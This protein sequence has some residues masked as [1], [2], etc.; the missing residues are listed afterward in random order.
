MAGR[1][2]KG[3]EVSRTGLAEFVGVALTTVDHWVRTGCPIV[4]RGGRGK[5]W[6]F[7]TADVLSWREDKIREESSGIEGVSEK[8]L[9][10]RKLAAQTEQA[11]LALA[12]DK[13][14]VAPI[15]QFER[16]QAQVFAELKTS[17]RNVPNRVTRM[18]I[19]E[20]DEARFKSVLLAELDQA[21]DTLSQSELIEPEDLDDDGAD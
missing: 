19:G 14:E 5:K 9:F 21:L 2:G 13:G 17:I 3:Q 4:E 6:K 20:T 15:E 18:L 11:E 7:N 16:A 12:R 8:E 1:K 10:R